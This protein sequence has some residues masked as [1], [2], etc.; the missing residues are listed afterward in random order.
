V[1]VEFLYLGYQDTYLTARILITLYCL[2][3]SVCC[4][5]TDTHHGFFLIPFFYLQAVVI[6]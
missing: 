2:V 3:F 6:H 5:A 1:C 4:L